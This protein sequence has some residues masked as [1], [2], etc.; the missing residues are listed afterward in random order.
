MDA[1][2]VPLLELASDLRTE[3]TVLLSHVGLQS[4]QALAAILRAM[5]SYYSNK[6]EGQH[7]YPADLEDALH[8]HFSADAEI[9][10]RQILAL[11]H[12]EVEKEFEIRARTV[13]WEHM[14]RTEW[15]C[16]MHAALYTRLGQDNLAILD[17]KGRRRGHLQPGSLRRH[18]VKVGD[19]IAPDSKLLPDLLTHFHDRYGK[20]Q[21]REVS[22]IIVAGASLHRLSW[23]HP[24]EDGNGRISRLQNHVLLSQLGLSEGLWSPMRGLARNQQAYYGALHQADLPRRNATDGRGELSS[25]G[26]ADFIRFWLDT[27]LDQVRFM[28]QLLSLP[29]METR[30]ISLALLFVHDFGREP[31]LHHRSALRPELLGRALYRL[32]RLGQMERGEFKAAL[33]TSDRTASRLVSRLLEQRLLVSEGRLGV[34]QPGFPLASFRYLFPGLWP[35]AESLQMQPASGK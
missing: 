1:E 9:H 20:V 12:M 35:E 16:A 6:I 3:A 5:N 25:K 23:I 34:L 30:Y 28:G 24:F 17:Q 10:T 19:H 27:C 14:F 7:T 31:V 22:K 2:L 26:L 33:D 15:I 32:F 18:A 4:R 11:A 8:R 13:M 21:Y 29:E